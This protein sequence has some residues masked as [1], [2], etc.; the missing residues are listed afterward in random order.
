[1]VCRDP[2]LIVTLSACRHCSVSPSRRDARIH[3]FGCTLSSVAGASATFLREIR[4]EPDSIEEVDDADKAGK[5][6]EIEED[7][8][9]RIV[10]RRS[11][12]NGTKGVYI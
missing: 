8:K 9:H 10:S 12:S 11:D 3:F 7:T 6:E 2:L 1:M 5:N 4:G